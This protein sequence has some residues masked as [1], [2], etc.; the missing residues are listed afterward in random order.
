MLLIFSSSF[1]NISAAVS[2]T[3]RRARLSSVQRNKKM[4]LQQ[5]ITLINEY[6]I[7]DLNQYCVCYCAKQKT[8]TGDTG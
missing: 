7:D 1:T 2:T 3:F 8:K 5:R 4:N 6:P